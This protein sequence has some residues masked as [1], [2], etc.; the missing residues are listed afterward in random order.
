MQDE[1]AF[2][3]KQSI[4]KLLSLPYDKLVSRT[5][6]D[7]NVLSEYNLHDKL[8]FRPSTGSSIKTIN[9]S[10]RKDKYRQLSSSTAKQSVDRNKSLKSTGVVV[11]SDALPDK[12]QTTSQVQ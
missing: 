7:V 6:T 10:D 4:G 5:K 11:N 12:K 8:Q 1:T 2:Q 9:L 3:K